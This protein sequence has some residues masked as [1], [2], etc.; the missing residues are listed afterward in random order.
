MKKLR[1]SGDKWLVS[2]HRAG[3]GGA[4]IQSH[5]WLPTELGSQPPG[6]SFQLHTHSGAGVSVEK[7]PEN[8]ESEKNNN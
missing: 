7:V 3:G 6:F 1:L 8:E 5:V 2:S 4:G